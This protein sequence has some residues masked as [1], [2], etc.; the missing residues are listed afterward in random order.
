MNAIIQ[1]WHMSFLFVVVCWLA[2]G[3]STT[4]FHNQVIDVTNRPEWW[5]ELHLGQILCVKEDMLVSEKG[6]SLR[7]DML[8]PGV[9][10]GTNHGRTISVETFKANPAKYKPRIQLVSAGTRLRCARLER[11]LTS[12]F[13]MYYLY[14]EILDG[15]A[16]G[17][18]AF[19][20]CASGNPRKK[21]SLRL[22]TFF[23]ERCR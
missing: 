20:P 22:T 8:P 7:P 11:V 15:E 5:G 23:V 6:L 12:E 1:K 21:G 3:C 14:A 2:V 19:V 10:G 13:S 9:D 17:T 18:V 4:V 16:S